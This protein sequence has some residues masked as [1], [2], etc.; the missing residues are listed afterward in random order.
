MKL[1]IGSI[2]AGICAFCLIA[3]TALAGA[4]NSAPDKGTKV[5]NTTHTYKALVERLQKSIRKNKMGIVARASAT[6]GARSI[7]VT[8]PGNMVIMVFRPDFAVRMLKT[9]VPAGIEAPLRYYVT[10]GV[11]GKA[12]LTYRTA[13]SVFAPYDNAELDV[14]AKELDGILARIVAEALGN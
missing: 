2:A 6:L 9:S 5:I 13:S 4:N 10:E 12:S 14:M 7:G 1:L 8:I 11:D 3:N